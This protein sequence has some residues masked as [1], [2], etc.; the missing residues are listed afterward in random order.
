MRD[1]RLEIL[2]NIIQFCFFCLIF[3]IFVIKQ[4]YF[5]FSVIVGICLFNKHKKSSPQR[6]PA[7][8]KENEVNKENS[9]EENNT[10]LLDLE[11]IRP[12]PLNGKPAWTRNPNIASKF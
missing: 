10:K 9:G 7:D 4:K 1:L 2:I 11:L 8:G 6:E 12:P 3:C 5:I